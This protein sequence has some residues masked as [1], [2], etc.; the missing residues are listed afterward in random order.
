MIVKVCRVCGEEYRPEIEGCSDC[1][2]ELEVREVADEGGSPP[3]SKRAVEDEPDP[4][5]PGDYGPFLT[6]RHAPELRPY[7]DRLLDAEVPFYLR[8]RLAP[9]GRAAGGYEIRLRPVDRE[10]A[11]EALDA[12]LRPEG[13]GAT[14]VELPEEAGFEREAPGGGGVVS[15][16][17]CGAAVAARARECG[18][19]GLAFEAP[20]HE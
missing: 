2:G 18:E 14:L 11:L 1:G 9:D 4:R 8:P 17:A 16:P 5:P 15:C 12:L 19:C 6:A 10:T 3:W 7:A 20:D 13:G